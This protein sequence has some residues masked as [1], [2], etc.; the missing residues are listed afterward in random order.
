MNYKHYNKILRPNVISYQKMAY[1]FSSISNLARF[2]CAADKCFKIFPFQSGRPGSI[3]S[4]V[5]N[6]IKH[7]YVE[8]IHEHLKTGIISEINNSDW[9]NTL[10]YLAVVGKGY[11]SIQ[12][13]VYLQNLRGVDYSIVQENALLSLLI[14]ELDAKIV[15]I[16]V[17]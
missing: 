2:S 12:A 7:I 16:V 10:N 6:T 1:L 4:I 5:S 9:E 14:H 11:G 15:R 8:Y 13:D 17:F 3:I